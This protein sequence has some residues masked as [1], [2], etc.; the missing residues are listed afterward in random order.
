[1]SGNGPV[2]GLNQSVKVDELLL[3]THIC[4]T[5]NREFISF[6]SISLCTCGYISYEPASK[7]IYIK[8]GGLLD[9]TDCLLDN[10]NT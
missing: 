1:M 6:D 8:K 7:D 9:T 2:K 3:Y 10:N 4:T 5:C